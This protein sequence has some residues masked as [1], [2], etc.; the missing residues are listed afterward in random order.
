MYQCFF[1]HGHHLQIP[2]FSWLICRVNIYVS[3]KIQT[4]SDYRFPIDTVGYSISEIA[5]HATDIILGNNN[6][7]VIIE[8]QIIKAV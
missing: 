8:H 7:S 6:D 5:K 2:P 3:M 4:V 1:H